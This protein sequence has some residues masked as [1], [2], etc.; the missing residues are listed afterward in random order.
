[1]PRRSLSLAKRLVATV[2]AFVLAV[3]VFAALVAW[4]VAQH[5]LNELLDA[6]LAQT[7]ALLATGQVVSDGDDAVVQAPVLMHKYQSRVAFQIWHE[8]HLRARSTDAPATPLAPGAQPGLSDQTL[9]ELSWRVFTAVSGTG[10]AAKEVIYVGERLSARRHVLVDSLRGTLFSLLLALPLLALAVVRSVRSALR[11]LRAL[12]DNVAARS[13]Q[14][15][16][17][18]AEDQAPPEVRPLVHALNGLFARMADLL[19]SERRFTADAAHELRTPI[20]AIRMQAQVA[21]GAKDDADR[22]TA[23][24]AT[25]AGCDRATRLV[26]QLLQ[27]AR[28]DTEEA[29]HGQGDGS[30][31]PAGALAH[32]PINDLAA[33][34]AEQAAE[35]QPQLQRRGQRLSLQRP[36]HAVPVAMNATLLAVL[37]R[38]LLD[39]ASRYSPDGAQVAITVATP[40]GASAELTVQDGGPGL[41]D[42]DLQ[43]LGDRFFRV[44]GTG[45]SGSGLGWSIVRRL[46]HVHGLHVAVD[47]SP[48]L[49]GLRVRVVWPAAAE[50]R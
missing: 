1:M 26:E 16:A 30:A 7:A 6:H 45:Q 22:R 35:V 31:R 34:A 4:F 10:T 9:G 40:S 43:R 47:R 44:L 14:A 41:S 29:G 17:P 49:G 19:A 27:L 28:I 38:N 18:L 42:A 39:N 36:E 37:L 23:L 20:A 48:D 21:R 11:P 24:D 13:P 12:G 5:E 8:G 25:V 2:L 32:A 15:L 3:W 33:A 50:P 46:A